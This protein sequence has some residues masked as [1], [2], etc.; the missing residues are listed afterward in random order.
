MV[1]AVPQDA[2]AAGT[3]QVL[4]ASDA[5]LLLTQQKNSLAEHFA[6]LA[7]TSAARPCPL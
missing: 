4:P 7:K 2:S 3:T 6:E 5:E 1:W